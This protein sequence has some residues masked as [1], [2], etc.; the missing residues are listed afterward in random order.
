MADTTELSG[1]FLGFANRTP[2][3]ARVRLLVS[4]REARWVIERLGES[5]KWTA[6]ET[7]SPEACLHD[8]ELAAAIE[9]I[10]GNGAPVLSS[11]GPPKAT[12]CP[13]CW[14]I[15]SAHCDRCDGAGVIP[16]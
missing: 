3:S 7:M 8:A 16:G 9:V 10:A 13:E 6:I 2:A 11:P 12:Q 5:G 15:Q 1:V 4:E 14:G